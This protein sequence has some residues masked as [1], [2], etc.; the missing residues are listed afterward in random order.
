MSRIKAALLHLCIS[1]FVAAIA[2]A[3]LLG[4]WYPP[5][6]FQ[7]GGG[8]HLLVLVV[9]VDVSIG[10]LLTFIVFKSGKRGL[11]LDLAVIGILQAIA[12]VY[13]FSVIVRSRPVFLVAAVDRFVL[14]DADQIRAKD[15]AQASRPEWRHLSWSGPVMVGAELPTNPVAREKV[16]FTSFRTGQDIQDWP[17]YYVPYATA[18]PALL[19]RALPVSALL[20]IYPDQHKAVDRWLARH[21]ARESNTR[22]LP[23]QSHAGDL[24]M[25]VHARD[26]QPI[27]A[28]PLDPWPGNATHV[29]LK[30][31]PPS[32]GA[33]SKTDPD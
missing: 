9:G 11:K 21:G 4:V 30:N 16:M 10:P 24:V 8:A 5:P 18:A 28:L 26:C 31:K 29:A 14:V 2:V 17:K 15:L 33:K 20:K 6:Y 12:L 32:S 19:K 7:A 25:M 3:L 22:W 1:G 27:G 13:G 23:I